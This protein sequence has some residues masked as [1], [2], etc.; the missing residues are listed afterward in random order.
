MD[1]IKSRLIESILA[2]A[3]EMGA[4]VRALD[5]FGD[6]SAPV[7]ERIA[8]CPSSQGGRPSNANRTGEGDG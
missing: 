7:A 3:G 6:G 1:L 5:W 2:G 8:G 4:R